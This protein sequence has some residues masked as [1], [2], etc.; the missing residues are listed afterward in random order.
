MKKLYPTMDVDEAH[1]VFDSLDKYQAGKVVY[2]SIIDLMKES[3]IHL[4]PL[5]TI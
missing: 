3:K 4:T 2:E 1:Y 5:L